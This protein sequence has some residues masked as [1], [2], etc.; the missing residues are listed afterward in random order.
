M[1][2]WSKGM[3]LA[4]VMTFGLFA[5]LSSGYGIPKEEEDKDKKEST[6]AKWY[7]SMIKYIG[8]QYNR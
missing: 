5:F 3:K 7:D 8:H 4:V 2:T 1:P 6:K